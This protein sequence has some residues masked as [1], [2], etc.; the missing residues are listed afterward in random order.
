MCT[1]EEFPNDVDN[2]SPETSHWGP[3]VQALLTG[4]GP[5]CSTLLHL[6]KGKLVTSTFLPNQ[7][8]SM[9]PK[10]L[11][12]LSLPHSLLNVALAGET[13][14]RL[15]RT[16]TLSLALQVA[17]TVTLAHS[18]ASPRSAATSENRDARNGC[19]VGLVWSL[20]DARNGGTSHNQV[21]TGSPSN[22]CYSCDCI[23]FFSMTTVCPSGSLCTKFPLQNICFPYH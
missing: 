6:P 16:F 7:T 20:S 8:M 15:A 22:T 21:D 19:F 23:L 13:H 17:N 14:H 10:C 11:L 9:K 5:A 1:S 18:S 2:T 3:V 4:P 12:S